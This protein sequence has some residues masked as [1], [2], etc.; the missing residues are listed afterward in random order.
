MKKYIGIAIFSLVVFSCNRQHSTALKSSDKEFILTTANEYYEQKKWA[1]AIELYDKLPTL[2][3]GTDDAP[4]VVYKS[5][6][7]NYYDKNYKLAAHQ[8]RSF[9]NTFPR[10]LRREEAAYMAAVSYYEDADEYNLDQTSTHSAIDMLQEFINDYPNS[11]KRQDAN[12]KIEELTQRLE[13]KYFEHA[14][15]YFKMADYRAAVAEFENL[16]SDYPSTKLREQS[17]NY[18]M[19][20]KYEL[21]MNSIYDLKKDRLENAIAFSRDLEK[22]Y[23]NSAKEAL[24][25]REKLVAELEKHKLVIQEVEKKK[26]D[27]LEKQ[28]KQELEQRQKQSDE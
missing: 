7:A 26:V 21:A 17:F 5:A 15:Q 19:K 1:K 16:L 25:M 9:S 11:E 13:K 23:P 10:D 27:F 20:A 3:A 8:F 12:A 2:V 28:R 22:E 4:E 14:K 18:M 24:E 6:Y